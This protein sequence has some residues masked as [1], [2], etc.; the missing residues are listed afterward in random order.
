MMVLP[1]ARD[2]CPC[3]R[4]AARPG[5]TRPPF[6]TENLIADFLYLE[7]FYAVNSGRSHGLRASLVQF[8]LTTV[9]IT[10]NYN[11]SG[12]RRKF[13]KHGFWLLKLYYL[14]IIARAVVHLHIVWP[15][16]AS[17]WI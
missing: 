1:S 10:V 13:I 8:F 11:L 3:S 9:F 6:S 2:P 17:T 14:L 7:A 15:A 4:F 12:D 5:M 16:A